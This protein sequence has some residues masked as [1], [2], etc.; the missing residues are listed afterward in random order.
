MRTPPWKIIGALV[1]LAACSSDSTAPVTLASVAVSL[2]SSSVQV[3][4]ATQASATLKDANGNT[5]VVQGD[6]V[7][8]ASTN[9]GV[10]TVS[11]GGVVTAVA[12]GSADITAKLL[13]ITGTTTVTV[14]AAPP[15]A[16]PPVATISVALASPIFV[17]Q[18]ALAT[19]TLLDANGDTLSGRVITWSTG[20]SLIASVSSTGVV[21]GVGAGL[22]T[23]TATSEEKSGI[24]TIQVNPPPANQLVITTQPAGAVAGS[25]LVVQPVV[26]VS[27]Q[28]GRV[29]GT[30]SA[31]VTASIASGTGTLVGTTTVTAVNGLATFT[32]LGV[33]GAGPITLT[34]ASQGLPSVTSASFTVATGAATQLGITTQPAGAMSGAV[35]TTQPVVQTRDVAGA[36]VAITNVSV[37]AAIAGGTGTVTGTTTVTTVNGVATFTDLRVSG[38]GTVTIVFTSPGLS[39]VT[40]ASIAVA[41]APTPTQL[42][43][44]VQPGGAIVGL[45]FAFQPIIQVR[46]ALNAVVQA[47]SQAVT[48]TITTG[49]G[50]LVGTT[51]VNAVNGV[52][53][54]T[55]LRIN[56]IGT[57]TLTFTAAGLT[58]AVSNSFTVTQ[59]PG[60]LVILTQ[61]AGSRSG[62]NFTTQ[63]VIQIRDNTGALIANSTAPVIATVS[64]GSGVLGGTTTVNAVA[65]VAT[66]TNLEIAGVG[67]QVLTFSIAGT[68]ATIASASFTVAPGAATNLGLA[69]QP[70]GAQNAIALTTQPVVQV[71]DGANNAVGQA[72]VVVTASVATG[73][74]V[75]TGTTTS[76][77]NSS[78]VAPFTNLV[79]TGTAGP[80]TVA[81]TAPGLAGIAS[82][83]IMLT[84]GPATRLAISTQPSAAPQV[85]VPFPQQPTVQLRDVSGNG[86]SQA[87]VVVTALIATGGGTL[88]G[89]VTATTGA[90]GAA[91]FTNLGINGS[92][93]VRTLIFSAP[94]LTA[95]TSGNLNLVGGPAAGLMMSTQPSA[96]PTD[97]RPLLVQPAIQL[98]DAGGNPATGAGVV[99][100]AALATGG[101]ELDGTVTATTNASG[102]A[103]F[104]NL[105]ITSAVN[106]DRTLSFSAPSLTATTSATLTLNQ[107]GTLTGL[108]ATAGA[109]PVG[110]GTVELSFGG[111]IVQTAVVGPDGVYTL[112]F[113][114]PATYS[115]QLQPPL[116]HSMG[117]GEPASRSVTVAIGSTTTQPF[118]VQ[119]AVWSDDMQSYTT[120]AQILGGCTGGVAGSFFTKFGL[121]DISCSTPG[122]VTL[123]LNGGNSTGSKAIRYDWAPRPAPNPIA[124]YCGTEETIAVQPRL[125]P[126]PLFPDTLWVRFTSRESANFA[127]G[128]ASCN[129]AYKFFLLNVGPGDPNGR[130]DM[131]MAKNF[132]SLLAPPAMAMAID[133]TTGA[134]QGPTVE[135]GPSYLGAYHTWAIQ[136]F[137]MASA[138][139][140]FRIYYDGNVIQQVNGPFYPAGTIIGGRGQTITLQMGANINNGPDGAMTR[141]FRE[142]GIYFTRPSLRPLPP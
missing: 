104:T 107:G 136:V 140:T 66:F 72:G 63:P 87:G 123:D 112:P 96:N 41:P 71:R 115:V 134:T 73:G 42:A 126:A 113:L 14:I 4:Q 58:A 46:D 29:V 54:F 61:P 30:S 141:W 130:F 22:V 97:T 102:L 36:L 16:P 51:T 60:S 142:I 133:G 94:S 125:N 90:T 101:G 39:A 59:A 105:T 75:L 106:G 26:Q 132:A 117:A 77:T 84:V 114:T 28:V 56:A 110:G 99:V 95:V 44:A 124:G 92:L 127:P 27:D 89:T 98:R 80:Q 68:I 120:S 88:T 62:V 131:I 33:N 121:G 83:P 9:T 81:F 34:F 93:G 17:G 18:T 100:T 108:V 12:I 86:V 129:P 135:L 35:L 13:N 37:T 15:S 76:T 53:A 3:G 48:A 109:L 139:A 64:S 6:T 57:F 43:V 11:Q 118:S 55:N 103:T 119:P 2:A 5:F 137:N 70:G 8:W 122:K 10:A 74:G 49:G 78:G 7:Q 21:T 69:T 82:D 52:A 65:G 31:A 20:N 1:V 91:T 50:T 23:I 67:P 38:S 40:S 79:I 25:T 32:N 116:T 47:A 19:P 45:S 85:G 128:S 111:N 138:S 24:V